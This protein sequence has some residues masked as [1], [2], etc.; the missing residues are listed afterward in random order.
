[1]TAQG[2]I[3]FHPLRTSLPADVAGPI[4][5]VA[6]NGVAVALANV[7]ALMHFGTKLQVDD[8]NDDISNV[9]RHGRLS[10]RGS[11]VDRMS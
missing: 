4:C 7:I 11:R 8:V 3:E 9:P 2:I 5:K 10:R 1:M 6:R